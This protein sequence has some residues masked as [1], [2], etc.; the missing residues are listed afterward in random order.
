MTYSTHETYSTEI[1]STES[2][3]TDFHTS[4]WDMVRSK[5]G[6]GYKTLT[7]A[8]HSPSLSKTPI[9]LILRRGNPQQGRWL[10]NNKNMFLW[11]RLGCNLFSISVSCICN[12]TFLNKL[13]FCFVSQLK[14]NVQSEKLVS[15]SEDDIFS[16]FVEGEGGVGEGQKLK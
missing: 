1:Y 2:T 3:Q 7:Q 15:I 10:E 4:S 6:C 8:R 5:I 11:T 13:I 16:L 14:N 12:Y 9:Q